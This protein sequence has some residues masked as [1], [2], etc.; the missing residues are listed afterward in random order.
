[1]FK[2]LIGI[3]LAL[4]P[5]VLQ[6][7]KD[8]REPKHALAL[9]LAFGISLL[10]IYKGK[11]KEFKNKYALAFV[12]YLLISAWAAPKIAIEVYDLTVVN[13]WIWR[14][15]FNILVYSLFLV[16]VSSLDFTKQEIKILLNV[17]VWAGFLVSLHIFAQALNLHQWMVLRPEGPFL[18]VF[19]GKVGGTLG[20]P[21]V[22]A[23]FTAMLIPIAFYLKK[24]ATTL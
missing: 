8:T 1:M 16:T 10:A 6:V 12:G 18:N 3:G 9:A 11:L 19:Q 21:T 20:Q 17:M 4:I 15:F 24:A 22:A 5:F 2:W 7:G 13:F 14:P 23:P